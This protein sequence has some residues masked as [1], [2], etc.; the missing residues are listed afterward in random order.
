MDM[1]EPLYTVAQAAEAA[2]VVVGTLRNW[3]QL[4]TVSLQK[5][6]ASA[7]AGG[8]RL[9]SH[10][11]VLQ[12]AVMVDLIALGVAPARAS[13][14]AFGF[15]DLATGAGPDNGMT[16]RAQGAL[17]SE[18]FSILVAHPHAQWPRVLWAKTTTP[19]TSFLFAQTAHGMLSGLFLPLDPLVKRVH[20][21]LG[22]ND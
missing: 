14:L 19:A 9:L 10:R 15:S 18:P 6:D 17:Y 21:V 11:R 8:T 5:A 22:L 20:V 16:M 13:R 4:G 12:V 2:G 1:D 7:P 3:L